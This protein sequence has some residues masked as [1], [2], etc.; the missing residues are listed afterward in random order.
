VITGEAGSWDAR[1]VVTAA[2]FQEGDW[3]YM[4]YGGSADSVDEPAYFGLA[5]SDNLIRWERHPG[6]PI[7]GA[8]ARGTPDGG[9]IWFP[10]MVETQDAFFMLYEGSRG[11]PRWDLDCSICMS[12]IPLS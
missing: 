11:T 8:G 12:W 5:R 10:T 3:T 2:L 7:F 9:C 6:N 1:S 4:I